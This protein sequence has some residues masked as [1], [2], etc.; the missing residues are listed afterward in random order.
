MSAGSTTSKGE[1]G[2]LGISGGCVPAGVQ[3][4][5]VPVLLLQIDWKMTLGSIVL[6]RWCVARSE[7][8]GASDVPSK[9]QTRL[10]S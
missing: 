8:G 1:A 9:A 7:L 5:R 4:N 6:L 3:S 10:E 2:A